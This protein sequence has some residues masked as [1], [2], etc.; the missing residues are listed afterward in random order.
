MC[1]FQQEGV[2]AFSALRGLQMLRLYE[3]GRLDDDSLAPAISGLT[4]C[5]ADSHKAQLPRLRRLCHHLS[6]AAPDRC[7]DIISLR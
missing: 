1:K 3:I 4:R 7:A 2:T 6:A 5:A